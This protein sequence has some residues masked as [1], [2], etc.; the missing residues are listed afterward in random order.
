MSIAAL[1]VGVG[2]AG[3][4]LGS[5]VERVFSYSKLRDELSELIE[6]IAE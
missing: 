4:W 5:T 2:L 3:F 1:C 6:G